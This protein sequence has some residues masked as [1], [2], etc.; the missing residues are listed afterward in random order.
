MKTLSLTMI[1]GKGEAAILDRCLSSISGPLFDEKIICV[2]HKDRTVDKV[3]KRHGVK[4]VIFEWIDD[5]SAARNFSLSHCTMDY[6]MWLDA[7][8]IIT[9]E[10]YKKLLWIKENIESYDQY[11]GLGLMYHYTHDENG[12]PGNVNP[13]ERVV[14]RSDDLRWIHPIHEHLNIEYASCFTFTDCAIDHYREAGKNNTNRNM[15]IL[16]KEYAKSNCH[17]R[18]AYYYAKELLNAG[19]WEKGLQVANKVISDHFMSND[20]I[21]ILL[22]DIAFKFWQEKNQSEAFKYLSQGI[23]TAPR[24]A[25]FYC[26]VGEIYHTNKDEKNFIRFYELAV[27]CMME[28][29]Q[30]Q[31]AAYYK[32]APARNLYITYMIKGEWEKA[33]LYNKIALEANPKNQGAKNDRDSIWAEIVARG[34]NKIDS[35]AE[36]P[37][38]L[39][40]QNLEKPKGLCVCW[41]IPHLDLNNPSVRVRRYNISQELVN[42][43]VDSYIVHGY[44]D[45][46][47]EKVKEELARAFVVVFSCFGEVDLNLMKWCKA[48]GKKVIFDHCEALFGFPLE[49]DCMAESDLITCC[50]N[51]LAD[52][53]SR[54]GFKQ[55]VVLEDAVEV[56]L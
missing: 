18:M 27:A 53:T 17:P 16:E 19:I 54:Y 40:K 26:L 30:P 22:R 39:Q 2:T 8:D 14:K 45:Y 10:N 41:L 42:Q 9:I 36:I 38:V 43:G 25:E 32:E 47:I 50:S 46:P 31:D 48:N 6:I 12:L 4:R 11:R 51:K 1:V 55:C 34:V 3:I 35:Y 37:V 49:D 56:G 28:N 15:R 24:M 52:L 44:F 20:E 5:F 29:S 21:A 13:R 7:D 33:L 23:L